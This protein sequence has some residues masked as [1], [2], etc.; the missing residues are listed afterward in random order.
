[1]YIRVY[2]G[3]GKN[4][5]GLIIGKAL[6][7]AGFKDVFFV[8]HEGAFMHSNHLHA[9][10]PFVKELNTKRILI[11]TESIDPGKV[12]R[13]AAI[14]ALKKEAAN[15]LRLVCEEAGLPN[16]EAFVD[17]NRGEMRKIEDLESAVIQRGVE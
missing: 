7:D 10:D 5:L 14:V 3:E 2:G 13:E 12:T 4:T 9:R 11:D 17:L 1:M 6:V 8:G 15:I 16:P